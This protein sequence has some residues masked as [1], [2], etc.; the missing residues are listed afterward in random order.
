M[1]ITST[2]TPP[3]EQPPVD[4]F[5]FVGGCITVPIER[6]KGPVAVKALALVAAY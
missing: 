4:E 3:D 1:A 6:A 5:I 2:G